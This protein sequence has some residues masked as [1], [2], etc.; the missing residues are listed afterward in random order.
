M[1]SIFYFILQISFLLC[2]F[3]AWFFYNK[4]KHEER[5]LLI[6]QG[7]NLNDPLLNKGKSLKAFWL[8]IGMVVLGLGI[9][10]IIISILVNLNVI[11]HSDGIF[12]GILAICGG[13]A[14]IISHY[15]EKNDKSK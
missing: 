3:F 12:P 4:S 11:G 5:K 13:G 15:M 14:L 2:L 8:K 10:L 1:N 7:I 9:G 6:Q